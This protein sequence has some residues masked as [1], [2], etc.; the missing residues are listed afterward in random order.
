MTPFAFGEGTART[1]FRM[2]DILDSAAPESVLS[3][4]EKYDANCSL[5]SLAQETVGQG[6]CSPN[7]ACAIQ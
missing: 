2:R 3:G 6:Q 1:R 7:V 5:A 4:A